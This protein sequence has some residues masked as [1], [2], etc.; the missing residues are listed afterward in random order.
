MQ[1]KALDSFFILLILALA[2]MLGTS[3]STTRRVEDGSHLLVKNKIKIINPAKEISASDLE[4][5]VQQ[6]PNSRFIGIFPLKLWINA[7]FK[8]AGE[9][10]VLLDYDM[11]DE[12]KLQMNRYLNNMGFYNSEI[13]HNVVLHKKKAKRVVYEVLLPEPFRIDT[14]KYSIKDDS[15]RKMIVEK[16]DDAL[17]QP[18]ELFNAFLLDGERNRITGYLRENGYYTFSKDYIFYE[19]DTTNKSKTVDLTLNVKNVLVPGSRIEGE[20]EYENHKV[21][22]VNRVFIHPDYR[23][24]PSASASPDTLVEAFYR[25]DSKQTDLYEIIYTLLYASGQV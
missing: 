5:L 1:M 19:A 11:I 14:I 15:L 23:L 24:L 20:P 21:Y 4:S 25:R 10:P 8:N 7:L 2:M 16:S 18:G 6:K 17:I 9:Q 13:E 3:C 22:Y 12:S